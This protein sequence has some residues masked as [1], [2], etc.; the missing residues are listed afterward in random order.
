MGGRFQV[1]LW[2]DFHDDGSE[3]GAQVAEFDSHEQAV[4]FARARARWD[5]T[6]DVMRG[7]AAGK[8]LVP[9][10]SMMSYTVAGPGPHYITTRD[11]DAQ[12]L[13]MEE[14]FSLL[15]D[16]KSEAEIRELKNWKQGHFSHLD[17]VI[18]DFARFCGFKSPPSDMSREQAVLRAMEKFKFGYGEAELRVLQADEEELSEFFEKRFGKG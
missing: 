17:A 4:R 7:E 8:G 15:K 13:I 6:Q 18:S 10:S 3:E 5:W 14:D 9:E 12:R 2:D 16:S 11:P 1:L